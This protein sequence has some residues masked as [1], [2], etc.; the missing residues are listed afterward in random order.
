MIEIIEKVTDA[1]SDAWTA[2][3]K[4]PL[5][6]V[7]ILSN[8]EGRDLALE[9][10]TIIIADGV[11]CKVAMADSMELDGKIVSIDDGTVFVLS[12]YAGHALKQ[13]SISVSRFQYAEE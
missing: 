5:D 10:Q 7:V 2:L 1:L 13:P 3:T 8:A 6:Q 12:Q 4:G 9:F 11:N